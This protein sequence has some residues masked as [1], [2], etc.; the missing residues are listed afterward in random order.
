MTDPGVESR[1][2][3]MVDW[4]RFREE[5]YLAVSDG[6][7]HYIEERKGSTRAD[8]TQVLLWTDSQ[9]H[10]TG[11]ELLSYEARLQIGAFRV[12]L[13]DGELQRAP[14][15]VAGYGSWDFAK[16][17]QIVNE[18]LRPLCAP[19]WRTLEGN[20]A[21]QARIGVEMLT[22]RTQIES[23]GVLLA[24]PR[25]GDFAFEVEWLFD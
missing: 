7:R 24:L 15:G 13:I 10:V 19:E 18:S 17:H 5:V 11:L 22:V 2:N 16:Y 8:V 6:V 21:V 4:A 1:L 3:K 14:V 9:A 23:E 12:A 20:D 25:R